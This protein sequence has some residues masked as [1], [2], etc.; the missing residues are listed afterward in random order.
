M[1]PSYSY[2]AAFW[3]TFWSHVRV[4][5]SCWIWEGPRGCYGSFHY[6]G[7]THLAHRAAWEFCHNQPFPEGLLGRHV[8]TNTYCVRHIITGTR[9]ENALDRTLNSEEQLA[10]GTWPSVDLI[11]EFDLCESITPSDKKVVVMSVYLKPDE[12]ELVK[13]AAKK[14]YR[15]VA[16]YIATVIVPQ[17][18]KDLS[19]AN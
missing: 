14:Q 10:R 2:T 8:C 3:N 6:R 12:I 13:R 17:A 9:S 5:D 15:T 11:A 1:K 16:N 18:E 7:V 4:T 19:G